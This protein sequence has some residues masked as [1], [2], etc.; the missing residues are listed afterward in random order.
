MCR[1][2]QET[3]PEEVKR[4]QRIIAEQLAEL[5]KVTAR[6]T[7]EERKALDQAITQCDADTQERCADQVR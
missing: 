3:L 1:D 7:P 5:K 6:L 2:E 4:R